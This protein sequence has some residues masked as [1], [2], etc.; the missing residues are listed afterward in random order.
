[1]SSESESSESTEINAGLVFII[2]L[3]IHPGFLTKIATKTGPGDYAGDQTASSDAVLT[4]R[5]CDPAGICC[6][7]PDLDNPGYDDRE[8]GNTDFF[9]GSVLGTCQKVEPNLTQ[10]FFI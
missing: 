5:V 9:T 10:W 1:M 7:T 6:K 4:M 2:G 3:L 8:L